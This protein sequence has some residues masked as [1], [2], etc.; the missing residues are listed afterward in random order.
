MTA[1]LWLESMTGAEPDFHACARLFEQ[2][3]FARI[4]RAKASAAL[5][6]RELSA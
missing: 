5:L 3:G 6:R 1:T 2:P 4:D